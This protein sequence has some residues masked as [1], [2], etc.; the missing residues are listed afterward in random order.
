[1]R[2]LALPSANRPTGPQTACATDASNRCQRGFAHRRLRTQ[3]S[4][5]LPSR[6][7]T[8]SRFFKAAGVPYYS[9]APIPVPCAPRD[10]S[11]FRSTPPPDCCAPSPGPTRTASSPPPAVRIGLGERDAQIVTRHLRARVQLATPPGTR[12]RPRRS[13]SASAGCS[14]DC[15]ADNPRRAP[16]PAPCDAPVRRAASS[17]ISSRRM[18]SQE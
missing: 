16:V 9:R 7:A 14:R 2:V 12:R 3:R 17:P 4:A 8:N 5:G 11:L 18:P 13:S 1:M 15:C 6:R 10:S